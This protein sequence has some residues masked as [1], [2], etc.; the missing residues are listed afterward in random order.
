M[1]LH[2]NG[3]ISWVKCHAMKCP[4]DYTLPH[5]PYEYHE[6][7]VMTWNVPEIKPYLMAHVS[8]SYTRN[9]QHF[10]GQEQIRP[11][12]RCNIE[13]LVLILHIKDEANW[14]WACTT[15]SPPIK[16]K[17]NSKWRCQWAT[18][19]FS[20]NPQHSSMIARIILQ[21]RVS[22]TYLGVRSQLKYG[23]TLQVYNEASRPPLSNFT[24]IPLR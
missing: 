12:K 23:T 5:G 20:N 10:K 4:W 18:P 17:Q 2:V 11:E 15:L 8:M 19:L 14:Q 9:I 16:W 24:L 13:R 22:S 6:W 1:E 7:S 21:L 3:W